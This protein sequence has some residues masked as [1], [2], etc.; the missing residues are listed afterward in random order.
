VA[1]ASEFTCVAL[2]AQGM[3]AVFLQRMLRETNPQTVLIRT[4]LIISQMARRQK[5]G[6]VNGMSL[7][8]DLIHKA[9]IYSALRKLLNHADAAVRMRVCNLI[10]E[11]LPSW[12]IAM[13]AGSIVKQTTGHALMPVL[14]S[15]LDP[16]TSW[17]HI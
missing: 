8:Y 9:D 13:S 3:S 14:R 11:C 2:Q 10:G 7:N 12:K 6:T 16:Q 1:S 4:L 15:R 17:S 5:V